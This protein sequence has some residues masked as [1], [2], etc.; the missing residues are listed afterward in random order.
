MCFI[1][2]PVNVGDS[3]SGLFSIV[4]DPDPDGGGFLGILS[5]CTGCD[6]DVST[7]AYYVSWAA[8]QQAM[9]QHIT[10]HGDQVIE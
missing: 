8:I 2:E 1:E 3:G 9:N 4:Y 10:L 7:T 5:A 6:P